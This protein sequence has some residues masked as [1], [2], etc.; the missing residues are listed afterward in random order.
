MF[1][2]M[3]DQLLRAVRVARTSTFMVLTPHTHRPTSTM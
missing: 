2:Y 1:D 3:H